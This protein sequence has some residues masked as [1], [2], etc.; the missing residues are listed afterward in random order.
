M[1]IW[2]IRRD[3]RLSDNA[4]LH[5]ALAEQRGVLPLFMLDPHAQR[6][7]A[8]KR[9]A[10]L[11]A[12]LRQLD[13]DLRARGS[14]LL[15]CEGRP[16]DVFGRLKAR[17]T[18]DGIFVEEAYDPCTRRSDH[19]LAA[20]L[21]LRL[22]PGLTVHH[23]A[24]VHKQD[25]SPYTVYTPF[26]RFWRTLPVPSAA[27]LLPA[28]DRLPPVPEDFGCCEMPEAN[29]PESFAPGEGEAQRRLARFAAGHDAPICSYRS[30][31]DLPGQDGTSTLS[32]Y[33]RFGM[34]SARQAVAA[35]LRAAC[36]DGEGAQT[37]L[38]ELV[39]REFY[40][41]VLWRFPHVLQE[42][43]Q[44]ALRDIAW[45]NGD[46]DFAAWCAG[47]TGYP[48]VDAAIRQLVQT[49]WMH[50]RARMIAA[51]FLVKDLLVDWRWGERFF[52]E[53]LIDGD[54]AANNG[55]W[56]WTAGVGTDAA[57]Y[58]RVFNPLLQ[59]R[60]FDAGGVYVRRWLPGLARVPD[61]YL[62]APWEMPADVQQAAGCRIGVDY[63]APIIEHDLARQ[64]T[65]AAYRAA[66]Q[67]ARE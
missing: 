23:P 5:A 40:H 32:P 19:D 8:A 10:F 28:P 33:L 4:A 63:P 15:V 34:V 66:Q 35:A 45:L 27:D 16:A 6:F 52:M 36:H 65:L 29:P 43:F 20:T 31:R 38:N 49:G 47:Q 42:A 50:N 13:H 41:A 37:W 46:D 14:R 58:F 53:H 18:V 48:I 44:P 2:W 25:G 30:G 59:A 21:P 67:D 54:A 7:P 57:P 22:C 24:Q 56:Q 3:L 61:A 11:L 26:M 12:G 64:R 55:G 51:S 39:W 60:K 9:R 62:H 1:N 17:T